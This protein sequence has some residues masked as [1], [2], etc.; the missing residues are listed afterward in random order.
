VDVIPE[1]V[2]DVMKTSQHWI[3]RVAG[4][5]TLAVET[6]KILGYRSRGWI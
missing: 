3:A 5:D 4:F 2:P 6:V 1:A